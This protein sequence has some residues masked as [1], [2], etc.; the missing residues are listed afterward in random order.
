MRHPVKELVAAGAVVVEQVELMFVDRRFALADERA[1]GGPDIGVEVDFY[2]VGADDAGK[3]ELAVAG[4]G[5]VEVCPAGGQAG[6]QLHAQV[7]GGELAGHRR[8]LDYLDLNGSS[9]R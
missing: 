7:I 4:I 9:R 1:V 2:A 6:V 5:H 3:V 8:V